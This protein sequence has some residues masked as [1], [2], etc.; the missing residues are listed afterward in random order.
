MIERLNLNTIKSFNDKASSQEQQ[1]LYE[2]KGFSQTQLSPFNNKNN[3][4]NNNSKDNLSR[5]VSLKHFPEVEETLKRDSAR[6]DGFEGIA[7]STL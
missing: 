3:N 1:Q 6:D 5:K 2:T 4:N 7:F